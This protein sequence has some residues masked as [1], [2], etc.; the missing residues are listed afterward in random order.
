MAAG[1]HL[2]PQL[3][4]AQAPGNFVLVKYDIPGDPTWHSRLL[5]AHVT[6]GEWI[7]LTPQGCR[8]SVTRQP[9]HLWMESLRPKCWSAL[10]NRSQ[11]CARLHSSPWSSRHSKPDQRRIGTCISRKVAARNPSSCGSKPSCSPG[12]CRGRGSCWCLVEGAEMQKMRG[13]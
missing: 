3:A 4:G 2:G 9:G 5:L 10:W 12:C 7:I 6:D 11:S 8:R 13:P 1:A